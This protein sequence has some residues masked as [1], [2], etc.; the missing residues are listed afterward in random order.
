[1]A[2]E[3][4]APFDVVEFAECGAE[5]LFY[6]QRKKR[7]PCIVRI[8]CPTQLLQENNHKDVSLGDRLLVHAERFSARSADVVSSPSRSA[9]ELA[10]TCWKLTRAEPLIIPN[11]YNSEVF[12]GAERPGP[13]KA[14]T[15]VYSGRLERLKGVMMLPSI[16]SR[17]REFGLSFQVRLVGNDTNTAPGNA[18]M[19]DWLIQAV[20][21]QIRE[22][23]VFTGQLGETPPGP[24]TPAGGRGVVPLPV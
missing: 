12:H 4:S 15:I 10:K 8:H 9:A 13:G 22:R 7:P 5:G 17:L 16:L 11:L 24:G 19:R 14:F 20:D 6:L 21:P 18:S 23:L 1:M 3:S 2:E